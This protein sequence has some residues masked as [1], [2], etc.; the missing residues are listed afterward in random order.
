MNESQNPRVVHF[1]AIADKWDGWD[2]LVLLRRRLVDGLAGFQVGPRETVVDLGCGTGNLTLALLSI[3]D[4]AGRVR[5][6]D[7][8]PK[9]LDVSSAKVHDDRAT[10][11][12]ASAEGLPFDDASND[13]IICFSVW[14]HL[15]DPEAAGRELARVL[16]PGGYVHVWHLASRETINAIHT[17]VGGPVAGDILVPAAQTA[18]TLAHTGFHVTEV[19]DDAHRYLVTA[20]KA[21]A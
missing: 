5:A 10:F 17:E 6:V 11:H 12:L 21:R 18:T 1:D 20:E 16:R 15:H 19:V 8:S 4:P 9:M 3:L 2:D 14:P 7:I 13:R